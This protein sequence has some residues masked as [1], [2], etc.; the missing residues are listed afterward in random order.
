MLIPTLWRGQSKVFGPFPKKDNKFY[1]FWIPASAGMTGKGM[2][3][4]IAAL[5]TVV[6]PDL[7]VGDN[8]STKKAACSAAF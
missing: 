7:L 2:T 3:E 6:R 5:P 4:E 1:L 8:L